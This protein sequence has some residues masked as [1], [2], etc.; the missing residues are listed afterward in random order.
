MNRLTIKRS[1]FCL[2]NLLIALVVFLTSCEQQ[3]Y[4]PNLSVAP[5]GG[6]V[7]TYKS[8]TLT[9]ADSKN[10]YGRVVFYK[11]SS[12]VTLVQMGLYNTASGSSYSAGIYQGALA[13]NST[14]VLKPLDAVSGATGGFSTNKYF[15]ISEAGFYD[16]LNTYNASVKI[17]TGSALVATGNIGANAAPVAQSL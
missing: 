3:N 11:Y 10:I 13:A 5:G 6:T 9:S 7:S 4:E 14:T 12:A 2:L 15:V 17:M 16:K 8:Y 1:A